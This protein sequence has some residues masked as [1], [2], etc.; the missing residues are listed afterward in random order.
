M[1]ALLKSPNGPTEDHQVV[2]NN[3]DVDFGLLS[4]PGLR[5]D[6]GSKA[7]L[8]TAEDAFNL[9]AL[10]VD[11]FEE[12]AFHLASIFCGRPFSRSHSTFDGN[13]T[14]RFQF[15]PDQFVET[16]RIASTVPD[17]APKLH[18]TVSFAND[19]RRFKR[20]ARRPDADARADHQVR[21]HV[22]AGGQLRPARHV[23]FVFSPMGTEIKRCVPDLKSS[24]VSNQLRPGRDQ[25]LLASGDDGV[26]QQPLEVCFFKSRA[27][28]L[29]S[30]EYVG[31]ALRPSSARRSDHSWSIRSTPR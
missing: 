22:D 14:V 26:L 2:N 19:G 4:G 13:Q 6:V 17:N 28:A 1:N 8:M 15:D 25:T 10:A 9:P 5:T 27:A 7:A 30:V 20:V 3:S 29:Q 23:K 18:A 12:P 21:I 31:T 11:A 16:F 24:A